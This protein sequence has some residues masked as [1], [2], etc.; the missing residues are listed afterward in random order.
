MWT[1]WNK[2]SVT[3]ISSKLNANSR[4]LEQ[5]L[6]YH[7]QQNHSRQPNDSNSGSPGFGLSMMQVVDTVQ[8]HIFSVPGKG[9]FPHAKV[10]VRSVDTRNRNS[11]ASQ[12]IQDR[13]QTI[14]VPWLDRATNTRTHAK[15]LMHPKGDEGAWFVPWKGVHFYG[16]IRN[17]AVMA[18]SGGKRRRD[19]DRVDKCW[20][21]LLLVF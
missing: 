20:G 5:H 1:C 8:V 2:F 11:T 10:Q 9:G 14:D 21:E 17:S 18:K 6:V 15:V 16:L 12:L 7:N 13:W 4:V 3:S 19:K